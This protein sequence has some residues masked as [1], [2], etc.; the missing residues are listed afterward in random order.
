MYRGTNSKPSYRSASE[1]NDSKSGNEKVLPD[2][3]VRYYKVFT[4]VSRLEPSTHE[5]DL[6]NAAIALIERHS[7]G[8]SIDTWSSETLER[9]LV[10]LGVVDVIHLHFPRRQFS[11]ADLRKFLARLVA[12]N[13]WLHH[14]R[15]TGHQ[16]P[17]ILLIPSSV[18][19]TRHLADWRTLSTYLRQ[20]GITLATLTE[21]GRIVRVDNLEDEQIQQPINEGIEHCRALA[22]QH[23]NR[24]AEN[25]NGQVCVIGCQGL[26]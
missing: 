21:I 2:R 11:V 25:Y 13:N 14:L 1:P 10:G 7:A 8:S 9:A 16:G 3:D 22:A 4:A 17:I 19:L 5:I 24:N 23:H 6:E 12:F 18:G 20:S 26:V 15:I